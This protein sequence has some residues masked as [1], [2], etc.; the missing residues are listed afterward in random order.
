M[1]AETILAAAGSYRSEHLAPYRECLTKRFGPRE[2]QSF[3]E[4]LPGGVKSA[5]ARVLMANSWFTR[6]VVLD[7]WFLHAGVPPLACGID[8]MDAAARVASAA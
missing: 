7:G 1:A 3:S 8:S 5:L 4:H 2:A 6:R